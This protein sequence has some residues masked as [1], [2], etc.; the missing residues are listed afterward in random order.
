[1]H[2]S[3]HWFCIVSSNIHATSPMR[4][5]IAIQHGNSHSVG[6]AP[7]HLSN[8]CGTRKHTRNDVAL[9]NRFGPPKRESVMSKK[10]KKKKK[11]RSIH[12]L[13]CMSQFPLFVSSVAKSNWHSPHP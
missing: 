5:T 9:V 6:A 12:T 11:K 3:L 4:Q 13:T 8:S 10:K 7:G 2:E 1:M